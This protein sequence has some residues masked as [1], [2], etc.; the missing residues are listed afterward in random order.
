M[1]SASLGARICACACRPA[2]S[3][4]AYDRHGKPPDIAQPDKLREE[5]RPDMVDDHGDERE[6]L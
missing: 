2:L 3:K 6:E 4:N 5:N 1:R